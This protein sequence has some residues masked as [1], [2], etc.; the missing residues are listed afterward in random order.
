MNR[1]YVCESPN[2]ID[3]VVKP[4]SICQDCRLGQLNAI[5][6][7]GRVE[8]LNASHYEN[9]ASYAPS[10]EGELAHKGRVA[11]RIVMAYNSIHGRGDVL[12]NSGKAYEIGFGNGGIMLGLKALGWDVSGIDQSK[13]AV[14]MVNKKTPVQLGHFDDMNAV[15]Q[16]SYDLVVGWDSFEHMVNLKKAFENSAN[17]LR[18]GGVLAIH[19]PFLSSYENEPNHPHWNDQSH[20]WHLS[21]GSVLRLAKIF[22]FNLIRFEMGTCWSDPGY[23]H[24]QNFC[25]WM[26]K[27]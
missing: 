9:S 21:N 23:A 26:V 8:Y 22:N 19:S 6:L 17:I 11:E 24:P 15:P 20:I 2:L 25:A 27:K 12:G 5:D 10:D 16:T 4:F 1:C 3:A 14:E 7:K 13:V 18:S